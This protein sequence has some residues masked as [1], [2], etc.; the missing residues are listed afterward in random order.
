MRNGAWRGSG[1]GDVAMTQLPS[2]LTKTGTCPACREL[3]QFH[4]IPVLHGETSSPL[5]LT[6]N[7]DM[8][9]CTLL[10]CESCGGELLLIDDVIVF[11]YRDFP[12]AAHDPLPAD[13]RYLADAAYQLVLSSPSLSAAGMRRALERLCLRAGMVPQSAGVVGGQHS[14]D[15]A[16]FLIARLP[17]NMTKSL[18]KIH[19]MRNERVFTGIDWDEEEPAVHALS[20]I[21]EAAANA[22]APNLSAN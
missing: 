17:L 15:Y 1:K 6:H 3:C 14:E 9:H 13:L 18:V 16:Q 2:V 20:A 8:R 12:P 7:G 19:C 4:V 11:P 5:I 22:L 10:I 21:L